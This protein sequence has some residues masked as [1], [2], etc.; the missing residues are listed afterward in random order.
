M[1]G[2]GSISV[3]VNEWCFDFLGDS[4]GKEGPSLGMDSRCLTFDGDPGF[5]AALGRVM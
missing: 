2:K 1:N 4:M 5:A 3:L